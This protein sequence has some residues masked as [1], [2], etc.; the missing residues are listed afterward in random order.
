M[1]YR[2]LLAVA[3]TVIFQRVEGR[4]CDR[5]YTA[6]ENCCDINDDCICD[7]VCGGNDDRWD[8]ESGYDAVRGCS[9]DYSN[10][11]EVPDWKPC[12][13]TQEPCVLDDEDEGPV[14]GMLFR[15][16]GII[17]AIPIILLSIFGKKKCS[18]WSRLL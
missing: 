1:L 9:Y 18:G 17:V 11:F 2:G 14:V 12:N 13:R 7:R 8:P 15:F 5:G 4:T 3:V 10:G 6:C 16:T